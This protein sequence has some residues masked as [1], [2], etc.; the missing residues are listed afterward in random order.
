M[1]ENY[2]ELEGAIDYLVWII[3]SRIEKIRAIEK[4]I[5]FVMLI[6]V[7]F[8]IFLGIMTPFVFLFSAP[9]LIYIL[10]P[11]IVLVVPNIVLYIITNT[12][13]KITNILHI[14]A[15]D[16]EFNNLPIFLTKFKTN[17]PNYCLLLEENHK[18]KETIA[19]VTLILVAIQSTIL[20]VNLVVTIVIVISKGDLWY[21]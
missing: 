11:V 7:F 5:S 12:R 9:I 20:I 10:I 15:D 8:L 14:N 18:R 21:F 4:R 6:N 16:L 17:L 1:S 2:A 19:K 3:D 13:L